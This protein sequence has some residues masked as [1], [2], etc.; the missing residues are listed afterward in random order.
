[1]TD[2]NMALGT[3]NVSSIAPML[4][5]AYMLSGSWDLMGR[6]LTNIVSLGHLHGGRLHVAFAHGCGVLTRTGHKQL[7]TFQSNDARWKGCKKEEE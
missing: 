2:V 4:E 6:M 1:M 7:A 3:L 5:A